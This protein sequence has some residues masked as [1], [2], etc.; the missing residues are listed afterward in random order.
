MK[1]TVLVT[2]ASGELGVVVVP[3]LER[4][5]WSVLAWT[6]SDA[7]LQNAEETALAFAQITD[8]IHAVVHLVGG[9][10]AGKPLH[11]STPE[12][13]SSMIDLNLRTTFNMMRCSIPRL[14]QTHGAFVSIGAGAA[15]HPAPFKSL[16]AASKAGVHALTY[17]IAE[18]QRTNGVRVSCIA[19]TIIDTPANRRWGSEAERATWVTPEAIAEQ[20]GELIAPSSVVSGV[21]VSMDGST[22]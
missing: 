1:P 14:R 2:G 11:E 12:D 18:E 8:P 9:I 21:V 17:A 13:F 10:R 7:D 5:G 4:H 20:V 22:A 6:H 16:Y 3:W 15:L 19:P